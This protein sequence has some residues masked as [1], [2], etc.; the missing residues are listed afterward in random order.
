LDLWT[1]I[2]PITSS[3][4]TTGTESIEVKRFS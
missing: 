3:R 4:A 2:T 1:F